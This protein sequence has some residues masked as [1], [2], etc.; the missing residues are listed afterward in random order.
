MCFA[1]HKWDCA[2]WQ[3]ET[4]GPLPERV[5]PQKNSP[6]NSY[7]TNDVLIYIGKGKTAQS[8]IRHFSDHKP[9]AVKGAITRLKNVGKVKTTQSG[10]LV[11]L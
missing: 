8:V 10:K 9:S 6:R 1:T 4:K 7:F 3:A 2:K 11:S 5:R